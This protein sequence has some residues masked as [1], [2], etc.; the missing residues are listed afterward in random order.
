MVVLSILIPTIPKRANSFTLLFNEVHRQV[1]YMETFHLSL[2][3]I[4]VI[5]D[6]SPAFLDGGPSIGRKRNDLLKR[7]TGKYVVYLDD[8]EKI[9]PSYIETLVRLADFDGDVLTFMNITKTDHYWTIVDMSLRHES[10][11]EAA[12]GKIVKRLPWH[13]CPV[14]RSLAIQFEFED[15][16]YGED[17]SWMERVLTLCKNECHSDSVIHEYN[18]SSKTS[19]ADRIVNGLM[20]IKEMTE[21]HGPIF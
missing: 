13:V 20:I 2:G 4:E 19:E 21:R 16:N 3:S 18:H 9:S 12:P 8:D 7:A 17:W 15:T 6:D 1:Q 11:E 5:V 14:K 10:N